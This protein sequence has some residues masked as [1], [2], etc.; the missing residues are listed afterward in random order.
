MASKEKNRKKFFFDAIGVFFIF[1]QKSSI[2]AA[3][4]SY[5]CGVRGFVYQ[6][7]EKGC[8][9]AV[10]KMALVHASGD[11][12]YA[13][14]TEPSDYPSPDLSA[15]LSYARDH[16]LRL[17][18]LKTPVPGE[19]LKA[20]EFPLILVL[21]EEGPLHMVYIPRRKGRRF[22]VYDP[23]RGPYYAKAETLVSSFTGIYFKIE[24]YEEGSERGNGLPACTCPVHPI[25]R[26]YLGALALL[27]MALLLLGLAFIDASFPPWLILASFIATIAA[28]LVQH[29]SILAAMQRF[30]RRFICG[31][32][33]ALLRQRKELYVHYHAYKKAAFVSRGEVLGRFAT[34]GS[35]LVVF[36]LHDVYLASACAMGLV[37]ITMVHLLFSPTLRKLGVEAEKDE[38]RYLHG[39]L[40]EAARQDALTA[41]S[42]R[43][44]R[45]GR[46]LGAKEGALLLLGLGLSFF[47]CYVSSSLTL[48]GFL[49]AFISVEFFLFEGERLFQIEPI[50]SEKEKEETY[51]RVHILP[52]VIARE[53]NR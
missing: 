24:S 46:I 21:R 22:R 40:G 10:V 6:T 47:A 15:I 23:K 2:R 38:E 41:L 1:V 12:R 44:E 37:F 25:T 19:L 5:I 11:R 4:S 36:L 45:Y 26:C 27:P 48:Q 7:Q 33:E 29:W 42:S 49:F 35:A 52:R 14:V 30:D 28:S 18:A 53:S 43:A 51:F 8:G 32:D 9:F 39:S 3:K 17:R 50:L 16:G 20:A 13:Y 34:V 31:I